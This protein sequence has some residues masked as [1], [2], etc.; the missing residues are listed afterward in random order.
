MLFIFEKP[1]EISFETLKVFHVIK[2]SAIVVLPLRIHS[3]FIFSGNGD[4]QINCR[5][6]MRLKI[7]T[8]EKRYFV[9]FLENF[10]SFCFVS[11]PIFRFFRFV[12]FRFF[13][14]CIM[15]I[16]LAHLYKRF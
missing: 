12:S 3:R 16:V 6:K 7:L 2:N 8:F 14:L 13:K 1:L 4:T 10:I 15:D 9:W 5:L 11:F